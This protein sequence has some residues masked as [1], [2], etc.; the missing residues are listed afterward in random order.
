MQNHHLP[1]TATDIESAKVHRRLTHVWR[2]VALS[3]LVAVS[4]VESCGDNDHIRLVMLD[5]GYYAHFK[6]RLQSVRY[7]ATGSTITTTITTLQNCALYA[8]LTAAYLVYGL[9]TYLVI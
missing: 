8:Q 3:E 1:R 7:A 5:D 6:D 4:P 2:Q 9:G